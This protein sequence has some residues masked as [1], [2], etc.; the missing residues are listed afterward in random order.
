MQRIDQVSQDAGERSIHRSVHAGEGAGVSVVWFL[1]PGQGH[2]QR[3]VF[4]AASEG[5]NSWVRG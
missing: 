2:G 3:C 1:L 5:I 4:G